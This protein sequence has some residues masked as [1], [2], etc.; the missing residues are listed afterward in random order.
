MF[1]G[2]SHSQAITKTQDLRLQRRQ[3]TLQALSDDSRTVLEFLTQ[4]RRATPFAIARMVVEE[5]LHPASEPDHS[6]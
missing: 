1:I 5:N 4:T 2:V 3:H 6:P